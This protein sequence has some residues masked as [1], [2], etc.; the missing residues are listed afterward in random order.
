MATFFAHSATP[1]EQ[2]FLVSYFE[3]PQIEKYVQLIRKSYSDIGIQV[4]FVNIEGER[5]PKSLHSGLV[6]ADVINDEFVAQHFPHMLRVGPIL[7]EAGVFLICQQSIRCD[8]QLLGEPSK[9]IMIEKTLSR[10]VPEKTP[11]PIRAK[12]NVFTNP[13]GMMEFMH[14]GRAEYAIYAV[15]SDHI[16]AEIALS[17]KWVK[18]YPLNTYHYINEKHK[19]I[20][21]ALAKAIEVNLNK[22]SSQAND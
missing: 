19:D 22:L 10:S 9:E 2:P 14:L 12:L 13:S 7:T 5:A 6:D 4:K 17:L 11:V 1:S 8:P 3:H 15:E 18:L 21:P 16:P 20:A